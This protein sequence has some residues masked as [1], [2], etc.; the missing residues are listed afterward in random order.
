MDRK[1]FSEER[2][3]V[4]GMVPGHVQMFLLLSVEIP[5]EPC[6]GTGERSLSS[7]KCPSHVCY[8]AALDF[9]A[10][11]LLE[12]NVEEPEGSFLHLCRGSNLE[13]PGPLNLLL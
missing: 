13:E 11:S 10:Y 1:P 2:A 8:C 3:A 4:G 12:N 5:V 9:G 6:A 7:Q